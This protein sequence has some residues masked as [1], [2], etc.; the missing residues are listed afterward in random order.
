M[1]AWKWLICKF[2][3]RAHFMRAIASLILGVAAYQ[4]LLVGKV[5]DTWLTLVGMVIGYYFKSSDQYPSVEDA[6][7]DD[8]RPTEKPEK[9]T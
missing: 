9:P 5:D 7:P 2:T 6:N 8:A 4:A 1:L 3:T